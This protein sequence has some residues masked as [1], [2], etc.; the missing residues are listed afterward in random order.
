M[1]MGLDLRKKTQ[2]KMWMG[3]H[4]ALRKEC[5]GAGQDQGSSNREPPR[6]AVFSL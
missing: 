1:M 6:G 4:H 2:S 3:E 5:L